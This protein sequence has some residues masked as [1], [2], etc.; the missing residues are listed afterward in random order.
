MMR[1]EIITSQNEQQCRGQCGNHAVKADGLDDEN[2]Q[3]DEPNRK[4]ESDDCES[5]NHVYRIPVF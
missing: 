2:L 1:Y 4:N 3:I 5:G